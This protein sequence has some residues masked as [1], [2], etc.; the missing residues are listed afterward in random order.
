MPSIRV[1][2]DL[3]R[4]RFAS[5]SRYRT[6]I[7]ILAFCVGFVSTNTENL[8]L[9]A[10]STRRPNVV[11]ILADDLGRGDYSAFGTKD[12]RTP[13]IDRLYREG[14]SFD[15]FL[16]SSCVCSPTR[17]ALLTGCFPDRVGVPG[18][19]RHR[20]EDSW[21]WLSPKAVL[22]PQVLRPAGYH[23]AIVGKW[24]LGLTSPNTPT[25]RGFDFFH[26]FLGDMMDD[27]YTHR[28]GGQNFMR[29]NQ[30]IIDPQGHAT[31]LFTDWACEY[32]AER[33]AAKQPFL[34][35]LAYNAP[36]DPIQPPP[37]W[38]AKVKQR[39]PKMADNRVALVALIE[40][41]DSGIGRV[42]ET[43]DQLKL[44]DETLVFFTSDNGGVLKNG[45]TNGPYRSEKQ[46]LYD[47]GLRVPAVARW[48][49]RISAGSHAGSMLVTTDLFATVAE[50]AGV[51]TPKE[52]DG[53]SFLPSMLGKPQA[54]QVRDFYFVRREGG[55][56]YGGKTIE[57][58]VRGDWKLIQDS[59]FQP[60]ELY[61]LASDPL[62]MTNVAAKERKTFLELDAALRRHIQRGGQIPWQ[63]PE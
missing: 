60:L 35:Y 50:A 29:R 12:I 9:S 46:H 45:A 22:L 1:H 16:A 51:E 48:P 10:E 55:P 27:Y 47:G 32:L 25:E 61:N 43:L 57:A 40:Q 34:L 4:T 28:R 63:E 14:M 26:G 49:G 52:I 44:A 17:A 18:V 30:E 6:A 20:P 56:A 8:A 36:H 19:I 31:E 11:I 42:L 39:E 59:P 37:E 54:E 33:A 62:E 38:I 21:G 53:I 41:M 5:D 7:L 23:S 3:S 2:T 24:H 13:A 58:L 15:N